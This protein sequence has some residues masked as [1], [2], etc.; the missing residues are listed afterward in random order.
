MTYT[1][2]KVPSVDNINLTIKKG[3]TIGII[4][5]TG[6]GKSTLIS[7]IPRFYDATKG[8][9]LIDG[10]DI[11]KYDEDTLRKTVAVVQQRAALFSGTIEDN[12]HMAKADATLEEM[13]HAADTAQA[14]EFIDRLEKGFDTFV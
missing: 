6:S 4:G 11:K 10:V 3:E 12:L 1:G 2:S 14:T 7:L 13:R 5:G 8:E 9:V